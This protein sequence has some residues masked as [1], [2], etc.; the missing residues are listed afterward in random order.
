[1]SVIIMILLIGLL[2]LVHE[3]G[4]LLTALMFKT[5][6][7]KTSV[8]KSLGQFLKI[9]SKFN[10]PQN[11]IAKILQF[12]QIEYG[13]DLQDVISKE[14][15]SKYE[16]KYKKPMTSLDII[17]ELNCNNLP[18]YELNAKTLKKL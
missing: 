11:N 4:H 12:Q 6:V 13:M 15:A 1:M 14:L 7:D 5:K 2:I 16:T 3:L 9:S 18:V 10:I 17:K 8:Y